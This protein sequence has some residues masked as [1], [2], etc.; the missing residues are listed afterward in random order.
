MNT[1]AVNKK[2]LVIRLILFSLLIVL[3]FLLYYFGK[4]HEIF[5]DNKTVD[6]NGKTYEAVKYSRVTVNGDEKGSI[7]LSAEDRDLV[8]VSGPKHTIKVEIVDEDTEKVIKTE[9]RVFNF[10]R[11]SS[12]MISVPAIAEKAADVYLPLPG[13]P[14]DSPLPDPAEKEVGTETKTDIKTEGPVTSE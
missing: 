3:A 10:G 4:E 5:L 6:I 11:T 12:L 9:E 7:E 1:G 13:I 14:T 2:R 8:K